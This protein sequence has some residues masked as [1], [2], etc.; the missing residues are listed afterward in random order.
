LDGEGIVGDEV[1]QLWEMLEFWGMGLTEEVLF[2]IEFM[3]EF[4]FGI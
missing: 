4:E 1:L 3:L 2:F